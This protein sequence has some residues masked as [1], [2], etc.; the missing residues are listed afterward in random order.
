MEER[1]RKHIPQDD[2]YLFNT[3]EA[4]SGRPTPGL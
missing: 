3:G 4:R 1:Y 2:I